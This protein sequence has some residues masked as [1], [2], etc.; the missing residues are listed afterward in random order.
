MSVKTRLSAPERRAQLMEVGRKVFAETGYESAAMEEVA[1]RAGVS[2]PIVYEHFGS[3][4]GLH[5]A[6]VDRELDTLVERVVAAFSEGAPRARFE[7]AVLAFLTYVREQ[8]DGFEVLTRD[9][10]NVQ[11]RRGLTRV[12]GDTAERVGDVFAMQLAAAGFDEKAAPI[13]ANALVGMVTQ[14]GQWWAGGDRGI[15]IELVARHV[16]ALGWMGLRHLPKA[17]ETLGAAT[18]ATTTATKKT[19]PPATPAAKRARSRT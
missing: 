9:S 3:K 16:A 6:I 12:I 18:R 5:A 7:N 13:Y 2:K 1:R 15:S 19:K 10:P 8:P 4:E 11:A 17:P 14:V